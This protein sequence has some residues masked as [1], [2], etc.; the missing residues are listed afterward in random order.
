MLRR[1][2]CTWSAKVNQ[3][4][5]QES[6]WAVPFLAVHP[7]GVLTVITG[8]GYS[9]KHC[10]MKCWGQIKGMI[11]RSIKM[12]V[13]SATAT[14]HR[15]SWRSD[16]RWTVSCLS[17]IWGRSG[18]SHFSDRT[19][20]WWH[21]P[22][23]LSSWEE[24]I[25]SCLGVRGQHCLQSSER[26]TQRDPV[27][28][29]NPPI[30]TKASWGQNALFWLTARVVPVQS[31]WQINEWREPQG[32]GDTLGL[33]LPCSWLSLPFRTQPTQISQI[34]MLLH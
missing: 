25:G 23:Y 24:N 27:S 5:A 16:I 19:Q 2:L 11:D 31:L 26:A 14:H 4:N 3:Y 34:W 12:H 22:F 32:A 21:V 13:A 6:N 30:L 1:C 29:S 15:C 7:L 18:I 17:L 28:K 10:W 9:L 33:Q 20:A 8:K